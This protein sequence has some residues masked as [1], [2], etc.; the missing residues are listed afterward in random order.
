MSVPGPCSARWFFPQGQFNQ[1]PPEHIQEQFR[2]WFSHWGLPEEVRLDNGCPW[3]GWYDLPTVF[4]MWLLGLGLK[5]H[6]NPAGHPQ[7]NGVIE[8]FNGL[9]QRWAEVEQCHSAAQ[10]QAHLNEVDEIQRA[11]MPSRAGP[12]RLQA[13]PTVRHS[14][15]TY[16]RPW[17]DENWD[18]E[19]VEDDLETVVATRKV[20]A[21]GRITLCYRSVY[22]AA[23]VRGTNVQVQYDRGSKMWVISSGDGQV[24]RAVAAIE[25]SRE[26]IMALTTY[27]EAKEKKRGTAK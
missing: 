22:V 16:S 4:A 25:V 12:S 26:K 11:Y 19:K 2:Q 8:R 9:G 6:F 18:L 7:D 1:V 3:G 27:Q 15:R 23:R 14:G 10:A 13:Y 17:E 24:L 5:V 20:G 21:Q